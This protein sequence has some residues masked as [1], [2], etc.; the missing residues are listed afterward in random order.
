MFPQVV[1]GP[2]IAVIGA[3]LIVFRYPVSRFMHR[4]LERTHGGAVADQ[5]MRPGVA[6]ISMLVAGV[7]FVLLGGFTLISAFLG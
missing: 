5:L 2:V 4:G 1:I 3:L 6:H 7:G